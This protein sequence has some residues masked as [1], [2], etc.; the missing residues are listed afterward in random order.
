MSNRDELIGNSRRNLV[1]KTAG[2]IRVL[3]GDKYYN[4]DFRS[5]KEEQEDKDNEIT[6]NFIIAKNINGYE[7][8]IIEYPG[9]GKII[10]TLDG[11]IYYTK[12]D[13]YNKYSAEVARSNNSIASDFNNTIN[14][15]ASI[16]FVVN[17]NTLIN[18]LNAQYLNGKTE[19]DFILRGSNI[20]LN[21]LI[22]DNIE[23]SDGSFSYKNGEFTFPG[24]DFVLKNI[25]EAV[26]IGGFNI[27]SITEL[28]YSKILPYE[29]NLIDDIIEA[30]LSNDKYDFSIIGDI[31]NIH[32]SD[33]I[34]LSL[35]NNYSK[36]DQLEYINNVKDYLYFS[37]KDSIFW[38]E[39]SDILDNVS[40]INDLSFHK[41][42]YVLDLDSASGI[43]VYDRFNAKVSRERYKDA[44]GNIIYNSCDGDYYDNEIIDVQCIVTKVSDNRISITTDYESKLYKYQYKIEDSS[45]F[46][47]TS[48]SFYDNIIPNDESSDYEIYNCL[49]LDELYDID[50][51]YDNIIGLLDGQIVNGEEV[52]GYGLIIRNN[53]YLLNSDIYSS[54]ITDSNINK[55]DIYSSNIDNSEITDSII[56]GC[57][58][59]NATMENINIVGSNI[60][61]SVE[62]IELSS[63][64]EYYID[65]NE[66][67]SYSFKSNGGKII[68]NESNINGVVINIYAIDDFIMN[69]SGLDVQISAR[70]YY[71]Y[72]NIPVSANEY[73]WV[74]IK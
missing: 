49:G 10:F 69:I 23:S 41:A 13:K 42:S 66:S 48:F 19:N 31:L 35:L 11:G 55:S 1:L 58:I 50:I 52:N 6:S 62:Y 36:D 8:G 60:I 70:T 29:N 56:D 65:E 39:F 51:S 21:N 61:D 44:S 5:E 54:D 30:I 26:T 20:R 37:P 59:K 63:D 67:G 15:K 64:Q 47:G 22:I 53:S 71:S 3:V 27:K 7:N 25:S 38:N 2:I 74:N 14:F 9:D 17:S 73:N 57:E 18:N 68:L 28:E 32:N 24:E 33:D 72:K 46:C 43:K 45:T 4:I 12:N 16:P 34:D 40:N